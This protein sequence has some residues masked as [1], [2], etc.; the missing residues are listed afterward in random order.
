MDTAEAPVVHRDRVA[1]TWL[2]PFVRQHATVLVACGVGLVVLVLQVLR[3]RTGLISPYDEG[4]HLSYVQYV[5]SGHLPRNGDPLNTW[6]RDAFACHQVFPY[7]Q[8]TQVPCGDVAAP[9]FYPEG[10]TNT[11]AGWPP[12]YYVWAALVARIA[13]L[14]GAEPLTGARLASALLWTAGSVLLVLLVRHFGGRLAAAAAVGLLSVAIPVSSQLGAFVTPYSAQLLLSVALT[15]VALDLVATER[16]TLRRLL[17][18]AGVSLTATL[19]VPHALVAV[20]VVALTVVLAQPLRRQTLARLSTGAAIGVVGVVGFLA[21]QQ[22]VNIRSTPFGSGVNL[23][24]RTVV[25]PRTP[26]PP[27]DTLL[28][29]WAQFWPNPVSGDA[30]GYLVPETYLATIAV[31]MVVAGV[32]A[33]VLAPGVPWST[34]A[35]ALALLVAAP[36]TAWAAATYFDYAVPLRYGSSTIG[37]S[38]AILGLATRTRLGSWGTFGVTAVLLVGAFASRWP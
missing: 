34:T 29:Q 7:G 12:L 35:L 27:V 8:V 25:A 37:I 24:G 18:A 2:P 14:F 33:A 1:Y 17:V 28:S 32:G 11:A 30:L 21:W 19:T 36:V 20:F 23:E 3:T 5:A 31:I 22:L 16:L 13:M 10:G 26:L 6:S 38:L 4:Y 15:W 9:K